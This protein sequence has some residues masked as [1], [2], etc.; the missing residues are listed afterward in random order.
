MDFPDKNYCCFC[1]DS[2]HGCGIVKTDWLVTSN[3]S[4]KGLEKLDDGQS[5]IKWEIQGLQDNLY[6]HK[7][8]ELK[9]PRRLYQVSD[10]L[11][12]FSNY[13]V[14]ITDPNVFNLPSYCKDK[15]GFTTICAA[16]RG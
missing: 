9:T 13:K 4:Y 2:D 1:C 15:C 3:A 5:Y 6:Y 11:M 8:D 16:L 10:D 14:G 7:D 12:D